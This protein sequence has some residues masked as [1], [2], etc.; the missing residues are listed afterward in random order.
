VDYRELAER[1]GGDVNVG[2]TERMA[3]T[4]VGASLMALGATRRSAVLGSLLTF[5]GAVLLFRGATGRCP[6][7]RATGVSTAAG[8]AELDEHDVADG[9]RHPAAFS[10]ADAE[11]LDAPRSTR[12]RSPVVDVADEDDLGFGDDVGTLPSV[13]ARRDYD[14]EVDEASEESFPASDPPSFT[15]DSH[16]GA[17]PHEADS[18]A[19]GGTSADGEGDTDASAG[20]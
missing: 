7:Y 6:V 9:P 11:D 12:R 1:L 20:A 8:A 10:R 13:V 19:S 2:R 14:D 5:G 18:A 3:S 16:I 15:P 17:P 4:A